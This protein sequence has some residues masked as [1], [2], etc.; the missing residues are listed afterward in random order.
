MSGKES[1]G[2]SSSS[3]SGSGSSTRSLRSSTAFGIEE[4]EE[5]TGSQLP[6]NK[7][8]LGF[9]LH[10]FNPDK[11][12]K[13]REVGSIVFKEIKRFYENSNIDC[14]HDSDA[15]NQILEFFKTFRK[16]RTAMNRKRGLSSKETQEIAEF[17]KN[18]PNIFDISHMNAKDRMDEAT[19]AYY[20][21]QCLEGRQGNNNHL[22]I[23]ISVRQGYFRQVLCLT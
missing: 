5:V 7:H 20:D 21:R 16:H 12:Q 22:F 14:K 2:V 17:T 18:L 1:G 3:G 19:R 6:S 8:V 23:C 10:I 15:I 11:T 9:Y 4:I 13:S